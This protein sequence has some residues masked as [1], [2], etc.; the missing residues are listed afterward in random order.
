MR[1]V[2]RI[3]GYR[4]L[5]IGISEYQVFIYPRYPDALMSIS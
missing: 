2:I 4:D 3:S 5:D 1:S